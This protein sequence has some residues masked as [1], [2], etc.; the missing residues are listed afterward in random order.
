MSIDLMMTAVKESVKVTLTMDCLGSFQSSFSVG[1]STSRKGC[2]VKSH[3]PWPPGIVTSDNC[4]K[5]V[6]V[7]DY[8][9]SKLHGMGEV[10]LSKSPIVFSH[11]SKQWVESRR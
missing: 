10:S 6:V 1:S 4:L 3:A 7:F 2:D 11:G 8:S 9:A 5:A